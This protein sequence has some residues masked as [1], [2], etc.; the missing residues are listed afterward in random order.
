ME[1]MSSMDEDTKQQLVAWT[2]P[3]LTL[4]AAIG[5]AAG[6]QELGVTQ[7][8]QAWHASLSAFGWWALQI[9]HLF[10]T[11]YMFFIIVVKAPRMLGGLT[12]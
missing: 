10:V 3:I 5:I 7:A 2:G 1:E 8:V 6:L 4:F 9:V 12:S 11:L